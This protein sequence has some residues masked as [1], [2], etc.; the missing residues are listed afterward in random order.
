M[1]F[2]YSY[3]GF[4]FIQISRQERGSRSP[5]WQASIQGWS[6]ENSGTRFVEILQRGI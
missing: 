5:E 1:M 3:I 4:F 6:F 2:R